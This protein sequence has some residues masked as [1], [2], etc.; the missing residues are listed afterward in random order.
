MRGYELTFIVRPEL[1]EAGLAAVEDKVKSFV[2]NSGG[3]VAR[4]ER[5]GRR[6]LA[7]PIKKIG[8][9]Q[10][11]FMRVQLPTQA[12]RELERQLRLT[13]DVLR[14]LLVREDEA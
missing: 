9:G 2:T 6:Q 1:D 7:Y 12:P 4:V 5:W 13:E 14:Y 10:Y 8:E 3:Q 11:I